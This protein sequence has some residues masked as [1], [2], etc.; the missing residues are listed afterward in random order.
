MWRSIFF[1]LLILVSVSCKTEF[2]KIRASTDPTAVLKAADEYYEDGKWLNAQTLYQQVIPF[3]RGKKEA[4]QL[5]YNYAYTHYNMKEFLLASHYFKSFSSSFYNSDKKEECEYMSAYC[6]YKMSPTSKLDQSY[7]EKA[8]DAF[9]SFA[10]SYPESSRLG[11]VNNLIDELRDKMEQK[12]FDQ[13]LLYYNLKQYNSAIYS[14][15]N[16]LKDFPASKKAE[17]VRYLIIKAGYQYAD[18]SIYDKKSE[19]FEEVLENIKSFKKKYPK[20]K[21]NRELS[22]LAEDSNSKYSKYKS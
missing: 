5:F 15:N 18:N 16:L 22:S 4:E 2:E 11:E 1:F 12:S 8:I 20:S 6:N 13:G 10:N 21:H 19:R 17:R 3:Y 14:F 7:S 9:Q